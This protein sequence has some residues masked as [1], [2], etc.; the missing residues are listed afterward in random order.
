MKH[1]ATPLELL[2]DRLVRAHAKVVHRVPCP[3]EMRLLCC[4]FGRAQCT[5]R[6]RVCNRPASHE[7]AADCWIEWAAA[8][9]AR[10]KRA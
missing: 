3:E 1:P 4:I 6:H 5:H 2:A 8:E 7:L 9:A 10:R